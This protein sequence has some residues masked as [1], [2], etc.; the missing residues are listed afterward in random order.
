[1]AIIEQCE[2]AAHEPTGGITQSDGNDGVGDEVR[3]DKEVNLAEDD[4]RAQHDNHRCA[5]IACA[6]Q[7]AGVDLVDAAEHVE[8]RAITQQHGTVCDDLCFAVEERDE[9]RREDEQRDCQNDSCDDGHDKRRA[10]ALL[11]AVDLIDA[12][13]LTD[14]CGRRERERLHRQEE[15]LVDLTVCRPAGHAIC[16]EVVN[17]R[18][19]KYV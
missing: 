6:A 15:K 5:G 4:E 7:H 9:L 16:T 1:M 11:G 8:R 3:H 12:E 19:Y 10:C 2:G 18:L 14:E 13:V 17:I